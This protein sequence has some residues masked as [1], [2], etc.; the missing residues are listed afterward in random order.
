MLLAMLST[1]EIESPEAAVASMKRQRTL[2]LVLVL[3]AIL[4]AL[5][6]GL[7]ASLLMYAEEPSAAAPSE[8]TSMTE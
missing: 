8:E 3:L 6:V 4:V 5:G 2:R 1:S 7:G